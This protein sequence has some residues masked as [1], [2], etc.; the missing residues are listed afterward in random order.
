[1]RGSPWTFSPSRLADTLQRIREGCDD[2]LAPSFDHS[3]GDPIE[4]AFVIPAGTPALLFEA[5]Y[6]NQRDG[7]CQYDAA[8]RD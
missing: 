2:L 7:G 1:M 5:N 3:F 8:K 6:N 4:R